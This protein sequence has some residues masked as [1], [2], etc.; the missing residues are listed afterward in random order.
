M[1]K[2]YDYSRAG[3]LHSVNIIVYEQVLY[4]LC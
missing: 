3:Y 4:V 2:S 1:P